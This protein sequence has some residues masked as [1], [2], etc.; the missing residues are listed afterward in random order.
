MKIQKRNQLMATMMKNHVMKREQVMK[1][2]PLMKF[3]RNL[4]QMILI[5]MQSSTLV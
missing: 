2:M 3:Q 1:L 4:M 5:M